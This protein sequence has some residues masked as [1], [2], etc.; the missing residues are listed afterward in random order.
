MSFYSFY[1][2]SNVNFKKRN[3]NSYDFSFC[4][5]TFE[6]YQCKN[7]FMCILKRNVKIKKV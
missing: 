7:V 5:S 2:F 4:F 1:N 6:K 3:N